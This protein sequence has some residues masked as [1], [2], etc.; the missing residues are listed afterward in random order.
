MLSLHVGSL[1]VQ[2]GSPGLWADQLGVGGVLSDW[3]TWKR[4]LRSELGGLGFWEQGGRGGC[5]KAAV[6]AAWV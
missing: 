6:G 5:Q 1:C 2:A 3:L 4:K